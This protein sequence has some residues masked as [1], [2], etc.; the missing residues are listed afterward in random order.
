M[1][2]I[3]DLL[4]YTN[5]FLKETQDFFKLKGGETLICIKCSQQLIG[6]KNN[7]F[8][9]RFLYDCIGKGII[10]HQ[11]YLE[12]NRRNIAKKIS[13]KEILDIINNFENIIKNRDLISILAYDFFLNYLADIIRNILSRNTNLLREIKGITY[14]GFELIDKIGK[15]PKLIIEDLISIFLYGKKEEGNIRTNPD[16][17]IKILKE[18]L[19]IK[20]I[21]T[22]EDFWKVFHI[23]RNASSHIK[24][25]E[26]WEK[27]SP[28]LLN[29][30]FNL[31]IYGLLFLSYKID[32]NI[33]QI[34]KLKNKEY[35]FQFS[36]E[37]IYDLEKI[38]LKY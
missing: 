14:E 38:S 21:K 12:K 28:E 10:Y 24:S 36:G 19:K 35:K 2:I 4:L 30:S 26:K 17:W 33:C 22:E 13:P 27:I 32:Y 37:P 15:D 5:K 1:I 29:T 34:Y 25:K 18:K 9:C 6:L 16:F 20:L 31:W 7:L 23:R 8:A 11:K 3:E